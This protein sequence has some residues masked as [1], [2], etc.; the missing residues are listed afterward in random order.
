MLIIIIIIIIIIKYDF[1]YLNISLIQTL[2]G[3]NVFG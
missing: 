2:P 1:S 3:P